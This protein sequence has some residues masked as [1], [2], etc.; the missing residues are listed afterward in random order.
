MTGRTLRP[1]S[2][3]QHASGVGRLTGVRGGPRRPSWQRPKTS[4]QR[5]ARLGCLRTDGHTVRAA[6]SSTAQGE[7]YWTLD[8]ARGDDSS[9]GRGQPAHAAHAHL[10]HPPTH[11]RARAGPEPPWTRP[12]FGRSRLPRRQPSAPRSPR[13]AASRPARLRCGDRASASLASGSGV[14][15]PA[16][17]P[18][19]A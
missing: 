2:L 17:Q 19:Q 14:A 16:G 13:S 11:A 1:V 12:S 4:R 18:N 9:D 15:R 3:Q 5:L 6:V 8:Q 7:L 10:R